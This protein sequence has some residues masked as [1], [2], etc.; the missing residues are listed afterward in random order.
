MS[1]REKAAPLPRW[2]PAALLALA[3]VGIVAV[4]PS[5][6]RDQNAGDWYR[7]RLGGSLLYTIDTIFARLLPFLIA[8]GIALAL[9]QR[10]RGR[11]KAPDAGASRRRHGWTE[12]ATHWSNAAGLGLGLVTAVWLLRW[13]DNPLSLT[14]TYV[15]HFIGAGLM[16]AA[17]AHHLTYQLVD[18]GM[19]LIPRAWAEVKNAAAELVG[20]T[21]VYRG[22]R[23]AFGVQLPAPVRR[24]FQRVLRRANLVPEPAGKYLATEKV[25][26]YT[27]WA[28]LIAVVVLTGII[29]TLR[30]LMPVPAGL[31]QFATFLHDGATIFLI[32][33]LV[34]HVGALVLVPRNWPLLQSMFTS[35]ISRAYAEKHL[36]RWTEEG[37][38][39]SH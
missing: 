35:R 25:I 27:I 17:V 22:L 4:L 14:T 8:G 26:S 33:F 18:G 31:R 11:R 12:M 7:G 1:V 24:P 2:L 3:A 10:Q 38:S 28:V 37:S 16:V 13:F 36:P 5:I 21:G 15:L 9:L 32:V 23:G 39:E 30:Y 34:I 20:Y 6:S 19:G 29:K